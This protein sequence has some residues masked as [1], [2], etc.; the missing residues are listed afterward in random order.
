MNPGEYPIWSGITKMMF[1]C[2]SIYTMQLPLFFEEHLPDSSEGMDLSPE[3]SRHIAQVLRMK[4]GDQLLVTDGKGIELT[5][6]IN[7]PDKRKTTVS[8]VSRRT[9]LSPENMNGIAISLLKNENRFEW[10]LEKATELGI[11]KIFPMINARTEK[12]NF[13]MERMK[14]IMVSAMIQSR[15]FFL[16][17][18]SAPITLNEVYQLPDFDQKFIAH[19]SEEGQKVLLKDILVKGKNKLVLIGPEGDFTPDEIKDSLENEF[20]PVSLGANR[21]RTETAGVVSAVLINS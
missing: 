21:L 11:R 8:F 14:N 9:L 10:F 19:C 1:L 4:T 3:S 13:R 15:Q 16:P 6:A 17:E 20:L 18:L 7:D 5:V 2:Y 12:K